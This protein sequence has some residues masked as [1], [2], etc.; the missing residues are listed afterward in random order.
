MEL[1]RLIRPEWRLF[2]LGAFFSLITGFATPLLPTF[3]VQP[4]FNDVIGKQQYALIS[5]VLV[6]GAL[7]LVLSIF[8]VAP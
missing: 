5:S 4:L 3:V 8:G 7:L 1:F 2:L 6:K